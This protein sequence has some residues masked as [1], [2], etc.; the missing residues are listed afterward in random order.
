MSI[1]DLTV[2]DFWDYDFNSIATQAWENFQ[3][4]GFDPTITLET[5]K[6]S[7]TAAGKT[8]GSFKE[9]IS[10]LMFWC[11]FRGPSF[12]EKKLGKTPDSGVK[13][14]K[15]LVREY[16]IISGQPKSGTDVTL[17]RIVGTFPHMFAA[18]VAK[19]SNKFSPPGEMVPS[20][21]VY[22]HFSGAP[23]LMN[24]SMWNAMKEP[25]FK[26]AKSADDLIRR[27]E[28]MS[29]SDERK[30]AQIK[31]YAKRVHDSKV[32]PMGNRDEIVKSLT[33]MLK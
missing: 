18:I 23:A 11:V 2:N 25:Y 4:Q 1:S 32:I 28:E 21:P 17:S 24:E 15:T 9:D 16:K 7:A 5:L 6:K 33:T 26:W 13:K 31:M 22:F 12:I 8:V 3:F 19:N 29:W 30:M 20:L 14:I 27:K 10:F